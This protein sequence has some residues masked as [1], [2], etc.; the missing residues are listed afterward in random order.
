[1]IP[2]MLDT[3]KARPT[4]LQ[5]RHKSVRIVNGAKAKLEASNPSSSKGRTPRSG[6][7]KTEVNKP[8]PPPV[9]PPGG[10]PRFP[11][12]SPATPPTTQASFTDSWLPS[13]NKIENLVEDEGLRQTLSPDSMTEVGDVVE[14]SLPAHQTPDVIDSQHSPTGRSMFQPTHTHSDL[15]R[16]LD[17]EG[18]SPIYNQLRHQIPYNGTQLQPLGSPR[19]G[20]VAESLD[21]S[22][23][24]LRPAVDCNGT[25]MEGVVNQNPRNN[26]SIAARTPS[27]GKS[28]IARSRSNH[29]L[30]S[31]DQHPT[32]DTRAHNESMLESPMH[33][34][35]DSG[36][37]VSSPTSLN[38]P[39]HLSHRHSSSSAGSESHSQLSPQ[40]ITPQ[41]PS[42]LTHTPAT[43]PPSW[44]IQD[45]LK[46]KKQRK[47]A[48]SP[49]PIPH[50]DLHDRLR[51]RDHVGVLHF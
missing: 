39:A 4:A 28:G 33:R 8:P 1:M 25:F 35:D 44:S 30:I 48:K 29:R 26:T 5:L 45:A 46:W 51:G 7:V 21:T 9:V 11:P 2:D 12:S 6:W 19:G 15:Q 10:P 3:A 13:D 27:H 16:Q 43:P 14:S 18:E 47:I 41:S 49:T 20:P 50:S 42:P 23:Q 40:T 24:H 31:L 17:F 37:A 36:N 22:R 34:R 32:V 38:P